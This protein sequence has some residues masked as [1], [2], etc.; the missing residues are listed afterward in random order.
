[1]A[2][3]AHSSLAAPSEGASHGLQLCWRYMMLMMVLQTV[4]VRC[5]ENVAANDPSGASHQRSLGLTLTV[6]AGGYN[7]AGEPINLAE[8]YSGTIPSIY[9]WQRQNPLSQARA[10][11]SM[12]VVP[13]GRA[14]AVGGVTSGGAATATAEAYST[15]TNFWQPAGSMA[16][17]RAD[18]QAIAVF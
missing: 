9:S 5:L 11:F 15:T 17:P 16:H 3:D 4:G 1:M 2:V 7:T 8:I 10:E 12:V 18:F 6:H 13:D 14:V